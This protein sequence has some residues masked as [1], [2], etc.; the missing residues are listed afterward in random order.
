MNCCGTFLKT[1]RH[2]D[3]QTLAAGLTSL[4]NCYALQDG[5]FEK[6]IQLQRD[7]IKTH[8]SPK[9]SAPNNLVV[10]LI[11]DLQLET[12]ERT[13]SQHSK[14]IKLLGSYDMLRI[15]LSQFKKAKK[16]PDSLFQLT[17]LILSK[18][19]PLGIAASHKLLELAWKQSLKIPV[20]MRE[21]YLHQ[22][23]E[24]ACSAGRRDI[25]VN[26][27]QTISQLTGD[28]TALMNKAMDLEVL[29]RRDEAIRTLDSLPE[30]IRNQDQRTCNMTGLIYLN[31]GEEE[32]G[33]SAFKR[34]LEIDPTFNLIYENIVSHFKSKGVG[35]DFDF[36]HNMIKE[37]R[38]SSNNTYTL[39][40]FEFLKGDVAESYRLIKGLFLTDD[41]DCVSFESLQETDAY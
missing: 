10:S 35:D 30:E 25:S 39:S 31:A 41:E 37:N 8:L 21:G 27:W 14:H 16:D 22:L 12:A 32:K 15:L 17:Y 11:S 34:G 36:F 20:D 6:D 33:V 9:S 3:L 18:Q 2:S 19:L 28:K 5:N 4:G 38:S 13:L 7:S 26:C 40:E 1:S 24:F 23:G 29:G